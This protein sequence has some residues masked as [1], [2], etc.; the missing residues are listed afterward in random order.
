MTP[1]STVQSNMPAG[2]RKIWEE[3]RIEE[4]DIVA[5]TGAKFPTC[6]ELANICKSGS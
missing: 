5:M 3:P 6:T 2:T 1:Y 4:S